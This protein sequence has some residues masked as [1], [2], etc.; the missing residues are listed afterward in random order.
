M[1]LPMEIKRVLL[2]A[3]AERAEVL[4]RIF[5]VRRQR[6]L[7]DLMHLCAEVLRA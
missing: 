2:L 4:G 6:D 1:A 3:S 5:A 7:A